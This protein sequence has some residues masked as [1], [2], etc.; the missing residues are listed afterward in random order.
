MKTIKYYLLTFPRSGNE[1][2]RLIILDFLK[3]KNKK[4]NFCCVYTCCKETVCI[5]NS[6]YRKDHDFKLDNI[7]KN[8]KKYLILYRNDMIEQ[9][10]AYFRFT[11]KNIVNYD[12]INEYKELL[13][14]IKLKI[15]YYKGYIKKYVNQKR[16]NFLV[17]DYNNYLNNPIDSVFSIL[18]FF[19]IE[20]TRNEVINFL[21][22][23]ETKIKKINHLDNNLRKKIVADLN[24]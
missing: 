11:K 20:C 12:N 3:Y 22:N 9:L 6:I 8:N 10:E 7:I 21:N 15:P 1:M 17:I 18:N 14:F 24:I 4:E 2:T 16:D 5:R 13:N 23:R 19:D